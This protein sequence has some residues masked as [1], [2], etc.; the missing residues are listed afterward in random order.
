MLRKKALLVLLVVAVML[1]V[2]ATALANK[3]LYK[4]R[5]SAANELH[6]VIGSSA[7]GSYVLTYRPTGVDFMLSVR[8][9]SGPATGI[10]LHGPATESENAGIIVAL[11]GFGPNPIQAMCPSN[12]DGTLVLIGSIPGSALNGITAGQFQ[13]ML[14]AGEVYVNVH[15]ALNPG[16]ETRG[17]L[18]LQ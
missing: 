6:E 14:N 8:G 15:T 2:P 17:Q 13:D 9:L 5:L 4:A 1:A 10:H 7:T 16:G 3:Q 18:I 12:P 11:C